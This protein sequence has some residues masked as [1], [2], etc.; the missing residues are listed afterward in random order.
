[1]VIAQNNGTI[2]VTKNDEVGAILPPLLSDVSAVAASPDSSPAEANATAAGQTAPLSSAAN[3]T[4]ASAP[5][6]TPAIIPDD[7]ASYPPL[8]SSKSC[9]VRIN[10]FSVQVLN[11]QFLR[12]R[13]NLSVP[14]GGET[15]G[16]VIGLARY[17]ARLADGTTVDLLPTNPGTVRFSIN[18]MKPMSASVRLPQGSHISNIREVDVFIEIAEGGTYKEPYPVSLE[19]P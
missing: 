11:N 2:P 18:Y 1:V 5:D 12:I 14:G 13:Y 9:P 17:A 6:R 15:R 3:A 16:P 7:P 4:Q 19:I 8:I 10:D